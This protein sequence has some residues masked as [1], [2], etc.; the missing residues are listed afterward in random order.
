MVLYYSLVLFQLTLKRLIFVILLLGRF[1]CLYLS[2]CL[3]V[4][5]CTV[6]LA[7]HDV[8]TV[9]VR[10]LLQKLQPLS[11]HKPLPTLTTQTPPV[12]HNTPPTALVPEEILA[13]RS[14]HSYSRSEPTS[15]HHVLTSALPL[16]TELVATTT[17]SSK[18]PS[19]SPIDWE[20]S[21]RQPDDQQPFHPSQWELK[22]IRKSKS[23]RLLISPEFLSPKD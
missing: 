1:E 19:S 6:V 18:W 4:R 14:R 21:P 10:Y 16:A 11:H 8:T 22:P 3:S 5:R 23:V 15:H 20:S 17:N 2:F 12:M 13:L 7:C 9:T